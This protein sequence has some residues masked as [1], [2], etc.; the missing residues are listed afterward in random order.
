[1][2]TVNASPALT[3]LGPLLLGMLAALALMPPQARAQTAPQPKLQTIAI[4]A[5]MHV[6]QAELAIS[7]QEQAT[8]M[9]FRRAMPGNEGMLFVND[10]AGMRCFWMKNTL[11]PITI[12]FIDDDGSIVNLADMQPQSEQSH[13]SAKPVRYALEM[14]QGWFAKRGLKAGFRLRGRPFKG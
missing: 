10:E 4:T 8:G 7:S 3:R 2:T 11:V 12:A 1:M 6:I 5:G 9:M 13:C 14:H